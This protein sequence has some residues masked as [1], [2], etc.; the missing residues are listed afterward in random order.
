MFSLRSPLHTPKYR[1]SVG[2]LRSYL[3]TSP[4]ATPD[5]DPEPAL[6]AA[7][8]AATVTLDFAIYSFTLPSVADAILAAAA[9]GV[10]VR[11][12]VDGSSLAPVT[13]QVRRLAGLDIRRW[14]GSYRLM[15]DKVFVVDT[16]HHTHVGL[17]SFNWTTQA[18]KSNVEVLLVARGIQ[19]SRHLA[20]ALTAQIASARDYGR[21][22]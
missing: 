16:G 15:H 13:S 22:V 6:V 9:R 18:E 8:D 1:L 14:G 2:S 19:A 10:S 12:V 4:H 20:P 21:A 17:G 5:L 11:G 7:I 3:Y